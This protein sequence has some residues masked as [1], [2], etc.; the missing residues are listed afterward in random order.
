MSEKETPVEYNIISRL[1]KSK[2]NILDLGCGT[3]TLMQKLQHDKE[4]RVQGIE[5]DEEAIYTCVS[6][7]LTVFLGDL[8]S[9]LNDYRDATFDYVILNQSIQELR[10][11]GQVLTDA[12]RVGR[13]VIVGFPNF[14]FYRARFQMFFKGRTPITPS[15]PY[16]W[17]DSPNL[18][19]LTINDFR[20]YCRK[21]KYV[22]EKSY[23]IRNNRKVTFHP[24]LFA[25]T[26]LFLLNKS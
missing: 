21:Q 12:L 11:P 24:N 9:G 5:I 18:H 14:G 3:G 22:L 17:Y 19:F 23:F 10:H 7:G 13:K 20:D 25:Q 6:K 26:G 1:I 4:A 2:S 8:D 16:P 15:L